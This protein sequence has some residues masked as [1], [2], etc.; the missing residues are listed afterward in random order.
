M[1]RLCSKAFRWS[2]DQSGQWL[3]IRTPAAREVVESLDP[4]KVY[5]IEIKQKKKK[6]SLD[7]NSFYWVV[8]TKVARKLDIS[9][10]RCHNIMLRR[11]GEPKLFDGYMAFTYIADTDQAF[12]TAMEAETSHL[13]PTSHVIVDGDGVVKREYINLMGSHEMNKTQFSRLLNGLLSEAAELGI[14]TIWEE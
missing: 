6:R 7:Q 5:S 1:R 12:E 11:Y 10:P 9:N 14:P 13:K 2:A 4:D 8:L 3:S